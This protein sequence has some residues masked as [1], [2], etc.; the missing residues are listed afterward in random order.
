MGLRADWLLGAIA[1]CI[2]HIRFDNAADGRLSPDLRLYRALS[3][4]LAHGRVRRRR[5]VEE[6][7]LVRVRRYLTA[8]PLMEM[9]GCLPLARGSAA[10]IRREVHVV[11]HLNLGLADRVWHVHHVRH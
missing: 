3:V 5:L 2:D 10:W 6:H 7:H 4:Y 8:R 9:P 1:G 11:A